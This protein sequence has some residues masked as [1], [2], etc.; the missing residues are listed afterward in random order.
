MT[1]VD[2]PVLRENTIA[3]WY[4]HTG[5]C[6]HEITAVIALPYLEKCT[7]STFHKYCLYLAWG[8]AVDW[9]WSNATTDVCAIR[10]LYALF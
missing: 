3:S 10:L 9:A 7:R 5:N 8:V 6:H 4:L 2:W 1:F